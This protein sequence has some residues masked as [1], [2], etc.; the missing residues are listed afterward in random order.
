[1]LLVCLRYVRHQYHKENMCLSIA[2][3]CVLKEEREGSRQ[4][5]DRVVNAITEE[6]SVLL[7]ACSRGPEGKDSSWGFLGKKQ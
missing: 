4:L 2:R 3:T 5:Q 6:M 1:M 7:G